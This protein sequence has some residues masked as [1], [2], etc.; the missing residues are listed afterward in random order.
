MLN[1]ISKRIEIA[2][3][4]GQSDKGIGELETVVASGAGDAVIAGFATDSWAPGIWSGAE[5]CKVVVYTES[6]GTYTQ[7]NAGVA[8]AVSNVD[9][10]NRRA[11]FTESGGGAAL[12]AAI[13][14]A[15]P[16]YLF[17][18]SGATGT[19]GSFAFNEF[20]GMDKII[21]NTGTLFN[22]S[23]S[24]YALWKSNSF[25]ARSTG[26][27]LTKILNA[28]ALGVERGLDEDV[29]CLVSSKTW[30]DIASD[31]AALRVYDQSY[32]SSKLENSAAEFCFHSQNGK[33]EIHT[34]I[35]VKE[36]EAF[37][38]PLKRFKRV[39]AID[40]T[41]KMPGRSQQEDFFLE[42]SS[43]AGYELRC[44]TDQALFCECPA[45]CVKI[46]NIVNSS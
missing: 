34:S 28:V 31:Q 10:I 32:K 6:G 4:Y 26:L 36:G 12:V 41:F 11:T 29:V 5:N 22:I 13:N 33:I 16:V 17:F 8:Y 21:S 38:V 42:L 30:A 20:A 40:V 44:Y 39:G 24:T 2:L 45:K 3:L 19:A 14:G 1:S 23:A 35:Y 43:Q 18:E 46:T 9:L 7:I 27:S 25:S 15:D 37:I